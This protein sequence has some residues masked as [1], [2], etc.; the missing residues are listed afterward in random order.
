MREKID[1]K[2][3]LLAALKGERIPPGRKL[4]VVY[5]RFIFANHLRTQGETLEEI[6]NRLG[7]DHATVCHYINKYTVEYTFNPE[8]RELADWFNKIKEQI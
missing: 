1:P 8:F 3:I 2:P 4:G 6:G 7:K 5:S